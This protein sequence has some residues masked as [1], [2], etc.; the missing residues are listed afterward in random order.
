MG[1][2]EG[3]GNSNQGRKEKRGGGGRLKNRKF[4]IGERG[5][6]KE[7]VVYLWFV[8]KNCS[9]F[10]CG[11]VPSSEGERRKKKKKKR[12]KKGSATTLPPIEGEKGKRAGKSQRR[13]KATLNFSAKHERGR[14]GGCTATRGE[15]RG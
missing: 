8:W 2:K 6:Q 4:G 11:M 12:K 3:G 14:E 7:R 15:K 9:Q 5:S 10:T 1:K 13:T